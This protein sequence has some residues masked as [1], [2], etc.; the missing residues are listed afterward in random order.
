VRLLRVRII[1]AATCGGLLDGLDV[2][3]RDSD[4]GSGQF[5][6]LC[7]LG[8]N[9]AGKS[10]FLQVIAEAFQVGFNACTPEEESSKGNEDL[11]FEIEYSI[12]PEGSDERVLVRLSRVGVGKRR[13]PVRVE[14]KKGDAWIDCPAAAQST[15]ELLPSKLIGYTS[16]G[17]ETLSL[18]FLVSRSGY[19]NA[20]GKQALESASLLDVRPVPDTRLM[21]VDY[22]THLEVLVANLLLGSA[23]EHSGLLRDAKL[24]DIHSFRC[25]IQ[26]AHRAVPRLPIRGPERGRKGVQLTEELEECIDQLKRCATCHTYDPKSE[27]FVFDFFVEPTNRTAFR[28]F[29]GTSLALYGAL[30]KLSMLN[31]LA[32]PRASRDRLQRDIK[33]R[34]FAARL[35]EPQDEDR[36]FR[37][38]QVRFRPS[39]GSDV[40]DY[41]SLSDGEHQLAQILGTMCM[42]SSQ[43]VLFLLDEPESHFNPQWR[44]NFISRVLDMATANGRRSDKDAIVGKQDCLL[45]THS[46]FV[47]SD[48]QRDNI[49]IFG[50][51]ASGVVVRRPEIE[52]YGA[53]F[54]AILEE[55][56]DVYPPISGIS[57]REISELMQSDDPSEI[58]SAIDRLGDSVEKVILMDRFRQLSRQADV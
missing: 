2:Q 38:E 19:A 6:P 55:C 10:Q 7:I 18:P 25:V 16:G 23:E 46:P 49:L 17:N 37:F 20:V 30:H 47:P 13:P 51:G 58:R 9:G 36:V 45:T 12:C 5:Q 3:L 31:D 27:T 22:G 54:D 50:K 53:T 35:P 26:L 1:R 24:S 40:V 42:T 32:I 15:R 39:Q 14:R 43:N 8:P 34:R 52:T 4:T 28:S 48:M 33:A 44:V 56:F 57:R 11:Q 29:W 41:V 21:L